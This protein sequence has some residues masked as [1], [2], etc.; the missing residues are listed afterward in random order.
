[1]T[2]TRNIKGAEKLI[3]IWMTCCTSLASSRWS[4]SRDLLLE[5]N[6]EPLWVCDQPN[7]EAGFWLD[8]CTNMGELLLP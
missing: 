3:S 5:Y 6:D 4:G 2:P 7:K 1:M 8:R